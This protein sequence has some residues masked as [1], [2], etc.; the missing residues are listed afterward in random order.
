MNQL[1][2]WEAMRCRIDQNN[3]SYRAY[4]LKRMAQEVQG[5]CNTY[6]PC[7]QAPVQL[8]AVRSDRGVG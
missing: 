6:L 5:L 4:R 3:K 8:L 7:Y 2:L 1:R